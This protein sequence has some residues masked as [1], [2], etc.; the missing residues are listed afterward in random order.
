M[1]SFENDPEQKNAEPNAMDGLGL[2]KYSKKLQVQ[3]TCHKLG[4]MRFSKASLMIKVEQFIVCRVNCQECLRCRDRVKWGQS[5]T[6]SHYHSAPHWAG[7]LA[8]GWHRCAPIRRPRGLTWRDHY[9]HAIAI[10]RSNHLFPSITI[11][12]DNGWW[13]LLGSDCLNQRWDCHTINSEANRAVKVLALARCRWLGSIQMVE[14]APVWPRC[15]IGGSTC[16]LQ[17]GR[18]TKQN[19]H[20]LC[21]SLVQMV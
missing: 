1:N 2:Q 11:P 9:R 3:A 6:S 5:L 19:R 14:A 20:R 18:Q 12:T 15:A 8:G 10:K 21:P 4:D 17:S 16:N 7:A 13:L